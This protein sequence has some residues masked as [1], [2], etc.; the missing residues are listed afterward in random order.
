MLQALQHLRGADRW[1]LKS[2]Q[3]LEQFGVL[4]AVF[5]D[6]TVV[7]T[8][9]DPVEVV[10]S[11]ATMIAYTARMHADPVDAVGLGPI[12]GRSRRGHAGR[13]RARPRTCS[14]RTAPSTCASTS[15]WPTTWPRPERIYE[16]ADQPLTAA[17]ESAMA[18]Y[19]A[20][21]ERGRLG[22]IDYHPADVGLD[23]DEL[24]IALRPLR[25][26]AS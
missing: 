3:H 22:R 8:H 10:V 14:T 20:G 7:V 17:A 26:S 5:P 6:A 25:C 1:V 9:R 2:P 15:S 11:L 21:H 4:R 18:D 12:L 16:L 23:P 19:L 13:L 24:R